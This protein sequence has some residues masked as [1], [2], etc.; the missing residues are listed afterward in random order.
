MKV[1]TKDLL[2]ELS[3]VKLNRKDSPVIVELLGFQL[4]RSAHLIKRLANA[5]KHT[6]VTEINVNLDDAYNC[7]VS[8]G[9]TKYT[10]MTIPT[11]E[12]LP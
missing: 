6:K 3:G 11:G 10:L 9:S 12:Q 5:L 1:S 8:F 4:F 2:K 7:I